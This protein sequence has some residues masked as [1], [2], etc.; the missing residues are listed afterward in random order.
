VRDRVVTPVELLYDLV[1]VATISQA[2]H[3][4]WV[5]ISVARVVEFGVVFS[6]IWLAWVNGSLY[7]ELHGRDDGRTRS[8]VFVQIGILSLLAVFAASAATTDSAAFAATYAAFLVVMTWL[9]QSVRG[10]DTPEFQQIT[11]RYVV[12]MIVSTLVIGASAIAPPD[13]RLAIWAGYAIAFVGF[14]SVLGF[15][16]VF[17]RG[18]V[19]TRSMVERFGLFTI[20]VLG[21]VVI[22]VVDG[23]S[24]AER[25]PL[26]VLT[27]MIALGI[28]LGFWWIYFDIIG[29]RLP[30]ATSRSVVGWTLLHLPITLSIAA[31]GAA[32][33]SLI[34]H[35]HDPATPTATAWLISGAVA[36]AMVSTIAAAWALVQFDRVAAVYR[37]L[38]VAMAVAAVASLFVGY[39]APAPWVMATILAAILTVTWLLAVRWFLD[40]NAWP[41]HDDH[42]ASA[43]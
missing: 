39:L 27:G 28:G 2:A 9:W 10:Q 25:D 33:V 37:K 23:I 36:L 32:M 20:I 19:P 29:G 38:A 21:E 15:S 6:M 1:Y 26:T 35:A 43:A 34:E 16:R 22:G 42:E 13:T 17:G 41:P 14:F 8:F 4:L 18:V 11:R 7:L 5:E 24:H 40:A 31:A 3:Q 12:V 30:R